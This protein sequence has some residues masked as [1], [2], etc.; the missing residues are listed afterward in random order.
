M[1][2]GVEWFRLDPKMGMTYLQTQMDTQ[3]QQFNWFVRRW[4]V[5]LFAAAFVLPMVWFVICVFLLRQET[6]GT[7][8]SAILLA[9]AL[10]LATLLLQ[11]WRVKP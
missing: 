4:Q 2:S 8:V 11:L 10:L 5:R 1:P 3:R 7:F 6:D 9:G